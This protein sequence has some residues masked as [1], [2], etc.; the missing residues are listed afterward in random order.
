MKVLYLYFIYGMESN[1]N[2]IRNEH[3]E[4]FELQYFSNTRSNSSLVTKEDMVKIIEYL[5]TK[6]NGRKCEKSEKKDCK[7]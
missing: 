3:N 2:E 4:S 6:R 5:R 7:Q 1:K